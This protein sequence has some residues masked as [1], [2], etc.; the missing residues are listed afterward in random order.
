[1]FSYWLGKPICIWC[2]E[3][4][5]FGAIQQLQLPNNATPS[6]LWQIRLYALSL[7]LS[8]TRQTEQETGLLSPL[9]SS[10]I[11]FLKFLQELNYCSWNSSRIY[12]FEMP[13]LISRTNLHFLY[14]FFCKC[15]NWLLLLKQ[16]ASWS[17][18]GNWTGFTAFIRWLQEPTS[19]CS[20]NCNWC[21]SS[22][23][24]HRISCSSYTS[25]TIY[26]CECRLD[27]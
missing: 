9:L 13:L 15:C 17:S 20:C 11:I 23:S 25:I 19:T 22:R 1:M 26:K 16:N 8:T 6:S 12:M 2:N 18:T 3:N 24:Y 4:D 21:T 14:I 7:L 5:E 10:Y 27:T